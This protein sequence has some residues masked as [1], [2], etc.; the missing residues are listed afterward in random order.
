MQRYLFRY[1]QLFSYIGADTPEDP[2]GDFF[3]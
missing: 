2:G 3:M 1:M